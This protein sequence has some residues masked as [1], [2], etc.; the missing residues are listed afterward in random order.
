MDKSKSFVLPL[1]RLRMDNFETYEA[2]KNL[3]EL[4]GINPEEYE[5]EIRRI[6]EDLGI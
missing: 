5:A 2:L 1:R 6:A 3:V 4:S